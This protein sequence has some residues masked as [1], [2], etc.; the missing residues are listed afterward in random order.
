MKAKL[1]SFLLRLLATTWRVH[2]D[3]MLP[4]GPCVVAFWHGRMLPVWYVFRRSG[5]T[6]LTSASKDGDLLATLL[7]DWG[8]DVV[9]GS[10]SRGGAEALQA[11]VDHAR[12][13]P[14][15]VTPD[16]PRGPAC[17]AK[18]GAVV[19]AQRADVPVIPIGVTIDSAKIFARSWDAFAL[20]LPWSRVTVHVGQ[21]IN[22]DAEADRHEVDVVI[23][24]MAHH[25]DTLGRAIC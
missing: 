19:A 5:S 23:A 22:I 12:A 14:V 24:H 10:S 20:P 6:A 18:A 21:P 13:R 3:G 25:L 2:L 1:A 15:L 9:R 11:M 17:Q 4:V 16:G 8:F 7:R